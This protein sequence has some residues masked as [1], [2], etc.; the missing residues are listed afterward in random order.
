MIAAALVPGPVRTALANAPLR[1]LGLISY[2]VYLYHW[3]IFLWLT[4]E[5][6]G[7]D[8]AALF[9]ERMAVD[10]RG[11]DGLVPL[12]RAADPARVGASPAG[13][14]RSSR[15]AVAAGDRARCS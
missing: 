8:G 15:A 12:D 7:L 6:T 5:R 3:P 2:G 1:A 13:G 11:R 10:A 4:P 14:P 9:G